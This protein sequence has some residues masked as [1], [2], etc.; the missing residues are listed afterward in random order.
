MWTKSGVTKN[1]DP[2]G[3]NRLVTRGS[4]STLNID[5]RMLFLRWKLRP[6]VVKFIPGVIFNGLVIFFLIADDLITWKMDPVD[7]WPKQHTCINI[8]YIS[9]IKIWSMRLNF[10]YCHVAYF[11]FTVCVNTNNMLRHYLSNIEFKS[12]SLSSSNVQQYTVNLFSCLRPH[13]FNTMTAF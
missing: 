7:K 9:F 13:V 4:F 3:C 2:A 1:I 6:K 5:P 12:L 11:E 10:I 8:V